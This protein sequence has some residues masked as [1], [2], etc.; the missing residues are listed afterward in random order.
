MS[1]SQSFIILDQE[2]SMKM[3]QYSKCFFFH[4]VYIGQTMI[5]EQTVPNQQFY[6]KLKYQFILIF[7][8]RPHIIIVSHKN[9]LST[10]LHN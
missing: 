5:M 6:L 9:G 4:F 8:R 1:L 7:E 2:T 3:C 10:D